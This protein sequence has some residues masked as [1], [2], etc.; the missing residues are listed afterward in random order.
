M[1][2]ARGQA[3]GGDR[4]GGNRGPGL[5]GTA[6][7]AR[8]RGRACRCTALTG[9]VRCRAAEGEQEAELP[10]ALQDPEEGEARPR[11]RVGRPGAAALQFRASG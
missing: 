7:G 2:A 5:G 3:S 6:A 4:G 10:Q 11:C 8:W 1:A 9:A